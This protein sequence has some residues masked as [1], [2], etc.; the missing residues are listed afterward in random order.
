MKKSLQLISIS[1]QNFKDS[2]SSS[3]SSGS[4]LE[5]IRKF[6]KRQKKAKKKRKKNKKKSKKSGDV[7]RGDGIF[8]SLGKDEVPADP[9]NYFLARRIPSP[10]RQK[11]KLTSCRCFLCLLSVE[12]K[13]L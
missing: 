13:D 10:E 6:K 7:D 4:D 2:S 3:E 11:E 8:C 1:N 5:E 9:P 12:G